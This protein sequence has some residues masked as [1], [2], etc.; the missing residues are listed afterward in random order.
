M[1]KVVVVD[2]GMG[3]VGSVLNMLKRAGA[4]AM[5]SKG[6]GDLDQADRLI[7]PGVG[8]FDTGMHNLREMGYLDVLNRKV[9]QGRTPILG[10]CI[11]AQLFT[12]GSEE[13]REP[14]LGWLDADTVRF[15]F[16]DDADKPKVPHMGWN[17]VQICKPTPLFPD[18]E[19]R[20]R[21]YFVHS[22][23]MRC[24]TPGD[25]LTSSNYGYEFASAVCRYNILGTQFHP[26]KSHRWGLELFRS[27]LDWTPV[28]EN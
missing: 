17:T 11:G 19:P 22:F 12:R 27:F 4:K 7:L 24:N 20:R 14:G 18:S 25:V 8:A 1:S 2:Y 3:N 10:I 21:F 28:T 15:R 13:G 26:E 16:P 5:L 9:L 23:H 6:P